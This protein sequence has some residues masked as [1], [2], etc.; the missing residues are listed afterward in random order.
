MLL[1]EGWGVFIHQ[2]KSPSDAHLHPLP[3]LPCKH[4]PSS[5]PRGPRCCRGT[6]ACRSTH[7][8]PFPP[9]TPHPAGR[10]LTSSTVARTPHP[11]RG[12]LRRLPARGER[13]V[14]A[15][16]SGVC[17]QSRKAAAQRLSPANTLSPATTSARR[18]GTPRPAA[19]IRPA[20]IRTGGSRGHPPL[21]G[22]PPPPIG[23]RIRKDDGVTGGPR[24]G[25]A[26]ASPAPCVAAAQ[27]P[28][29]SPRPSSPR[30]SAPSPVC[31]EPPSPC[32]S[33]DTARDPCL[34]LDSQWVGAGDSSGITVV[35]GGM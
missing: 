29:I 30:A 4:A 18:A 25:E 1:R 28:P 17:V 2:G 35:G 10:W 16:L 32:G 8:T 22:T 5:T 7:S 31:P 34:D 26:G 12:V 24:P 13:Q 21:P 15:Q 3:T 19:L 6:P 27:L 11:P 23:P 14:F 9:L 20:L 33:D